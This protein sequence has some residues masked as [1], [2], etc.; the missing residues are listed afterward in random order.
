MTNEKLYSF[1][2]LAEELKVSTAELAKIIKESEGQLP[3]PTII[4]RLTNECFY[5]VEDY[6]AIKS[7]LERSTL[8]PEEFFS[9]FSTG[10]GRPK[11][12][13]SPPRKVKIAKKAGKRGRPRKQ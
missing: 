6:E 11:K 9:R 4:N 5:T 7:C 10:R 2:E 12:T 8:T 13:D 3:I 1:T